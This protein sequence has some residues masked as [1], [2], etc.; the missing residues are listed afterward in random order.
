MLHVRTR[1]RQIVGCATAHAMVSA[2]VWIWALAAAMGLGFKDRAAWTT[3]DHLQADVVP[4][5]AMILT[6]PGNYFLDFNA[7]WFGI[8]GPWLLNSILW[9]AIAVSVWSLLTGKRHAT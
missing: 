5:L 2:S 3:W 1:I 6:S 4:L 9:A 7:G 8:V